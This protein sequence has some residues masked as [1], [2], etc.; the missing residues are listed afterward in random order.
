MEPMKLI[1]QLTVWLFVSLLLLGAVPTSAMEMSVSGSQLILSGFINELDYDKFLSHL[2][3][4]IRTVVFTKSPGGVH[5]I[6][7]A[8][9]HEIRRRGLST[10]ALGYCNSACAN[11]FLGGADR[12]LANDRSYVAFHGKL[13]VPDRQTF[14]PTLRPA[15]CLLHGD[16]QWT[17]KRP[18]DSTVPEQ[19]GAR[20]RRFLPAGDAKL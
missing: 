10:V 7:L 6:G 12:R 4:A 1:K 15:I 17:V 19:R 16:D 3:P 14:N 9:A 8:L 11:A 13:L 18:D 2:T 5:L 20:I